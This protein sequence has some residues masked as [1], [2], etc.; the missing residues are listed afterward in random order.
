MFSVLG[1]N[2]SSAVYGHSTGF[3]VLRTVPGTQQPL[4]D[5]C[6]VK[7]QLQG[8]V[9]P[10]SETLDLPRY[11][12]WREDLGICTWHQ[13]LSPSSF[14]LF[15]LCCLDPGFCT[16]TLKKKDDGECARVLTQVDSNTNFEEHFLITQPCCLLML[17]AL[18][19]SPGIEH[20][21]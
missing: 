9:F 18:L 4:T 13:S 15:C 1:C 2:L 10:T 11:T 6:C 17:T 16:S 14:L 5:F 8:L 3:L 21:Q 7:E 20:N 12:R 19:T